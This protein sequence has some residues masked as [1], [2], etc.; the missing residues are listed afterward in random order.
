MKKEKRGIENEVYDSKLLEELASKIVTEEDLN[1]IL[2][3]LSKKL[4]V[5]CQL[6]NNG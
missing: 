3:Q 4:L 2:K 6:S 1:I 5:P